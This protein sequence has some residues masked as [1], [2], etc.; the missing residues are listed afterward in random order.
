M[1]ASRTREFVHT[2]V[3]GGGQ[4]GLSV[5]YHLARRGIPFVILDANARIGDA[6]RRRWDSLRLFTPAR[7]NGLPGMRFPRPGS[8]FVSKDEMAD[9]LESY[10]ARFQFP[11]R[12]GTRV[13]RLSTRGD[14]FV[15]VAG[16]TTIEADNVVVA[17]ASAQ[18]ARIPAF[19][20]ELDPRIHQMHSV[21]YKNPAQ[22][23]DG[24]VL[25]VGVGNSG[26]DIGLEL[27]RTHR[28]IVAGKE[29]GHV[30]FR[31]ETPIARFVLVRLVRFVGH[32]V[33]TVRTP[34]GR[35]LRPKLLARGA[36]LVRV[37]PQ[38]LVAA[39]VERVPRIV[40][41][42]DGRPVAADG[43]VMDVDNVLWCTGYHPGLSWIDLPIFDADGQPRHEGGIVPSQPGLYF[44]GLHFLYSASSETITGSQRDAKRI[45]NALAVGGRGSAVAVEHELRRVS[46]RAS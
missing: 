12:T 30:P 14:R 22:L 11:L 40:G 9:Y 27:A 2:L 44:V 17:M 26:A 45:V 41:V 15:A 35:R 13:E 23:R 7:Y 42:R 43:R 33:L 32:H 37:K 28:T 31:I 46:A 29:P 18:E 25:V 4:A 6:W 19:A 3:I 36:P 21:E 34:I 8:T 1:Q 5:G 20:G 10:A 38:D 24:T 16:E 39:G